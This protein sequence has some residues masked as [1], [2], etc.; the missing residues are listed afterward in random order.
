MQRDAHRGS[1]CDGTDATLESYVI[2]FA[3]FPRRFSRSRS[4]PALSAADRQSRDDPEETRRW[5][6]RTAF[7]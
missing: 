2:V 6:T 7:T 5:T 1:N 3:T 4:T